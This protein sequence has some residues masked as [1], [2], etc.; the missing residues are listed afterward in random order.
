VGE[1][2]EE[3]AA[4]LVA[5]RTTTLRAL[6][7]LEDGDCAK[8][9]E[10]NNGTQSVNRILRQLTGHALDHFQ[11]LHRLLQARG[12]PLTEA[13]LLLMKAEAAQAELVTLIR[14]LSDT[15]FTQIG[16]KEGDWSAAQIL[17]HVLG[18]ERK[19]R[20][21]ILQAVE[22]RDEGGATANAVM[23][24]RRFAQGVTY[25]EFK[26]SMTR[27]REAIE[28]SERAVRLELS[29]AAFF[30][31]LPKPLKVVAIA[32]DWCADVVANL[33]ILA[34]IAK[35]SAGKLDVRVFEKKKFPDLMARYVNR[36][37][38]ESLPVFVFF[39]ESFR[40]V[41]LFIE[42]PASVTARRA[43]LRLEI[44]R[45]DPA[46]GT[47]D[48]APADLPDDIRARLMAAIHAMRADI[49]PWADTEVVRS[50]REILAHATAA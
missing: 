2:A 24:A 21:A 41:G 44:Y 10:W 32:E 23:D 50:L 8:P 11:H 15:E 40:E 14:S 25:E 46:F 16:P 13:Q 9:V 45:N 3:A 49:K 47:P 19:Y 6:L 18:N 43:Q 5:E 20:E 29:D 36:G 48:A 37:Q 26:A 28:A 31:A 39:D 4:R 1:Q 33:P 12:R 17:E 38:F 30:R 35:A 7:G 34:T 42:R 27:N 22:R